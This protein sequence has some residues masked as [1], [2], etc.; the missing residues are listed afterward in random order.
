MTRKRIEDAWSEIYGELQDVTE[1]DDYVIVNIEGSTPLAYDSNSQEATI[2]KEELSD[3]EPGT[4]I[5]IL[6]TDIPSKP[7]VVRIESKGGGTT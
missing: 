1:S 4:V 6:S 2:L 3:V 5:G 7:V